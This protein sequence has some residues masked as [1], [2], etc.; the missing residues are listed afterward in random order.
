MG[1]TVGWHGGSIAPLRAVAAAPITTSMEPDLKPAPLSPALQQYLIDA[2]RRSAEEL[3]LPRDE[4]VVRYLGELVA[5]LAV[6]DDVRVENIAERLEA[7]RQAWQPGPD[8]DP[9]REVELRRQIGDLALYITGFVWERLHARAA[10]RRYIR[11]GRRAYR[12]V[13]EHHRAAGHPDASLYRALA[14]RFLRYTVLLMYLRE[15]YVD[16]EP[17]APSLPAALDGE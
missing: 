1:E 14:G 10:Q 11:L 15:V 6:R 4:G 2:L 3:A 9:G 12:F 8:F 16:A 17:S 5:R 7:I 13:A